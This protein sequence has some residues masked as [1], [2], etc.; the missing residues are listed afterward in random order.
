MHLSIQDTGIGI[1]DDE[2]DKVF[3]AFE[4]TKGQSTA[5]Y[6]GTGLGLAITKNLIT[7][8]NGDINVTGVMGE[9]SS[10]NLVLREI[11]IASITDIENMSENNIDINS[12]EFERASILIIDDIETNRKLVIAYLAPFNF[13]L[14]EGCNGQDLLDLA[15]EHKPDLILT[16]MKMPIMDGYEATSILKNESG[17]KD[18]PVV[19]LTAS[20]MTDTEERVKAICDGYL[21]KPVSMNDIFV[22]L[23]KYLKHT[24]IEIEDAEPKQINEILEENEFI[25][26]LDSTKNITDLLDKLHKDYKEQWKELKETL[27]I[28]EIEY[29]AQTIMS[30]AIEHKYLPLKKWGS[31]LS[32]QASMFE[33]DAM[34]LT[35]EKFPEILK[36]IESYIINT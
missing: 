21:R 31:Q 15:R 10:F 26:S 8:M 18:I 17:I 27:T 25:F 30:L 9:G 22:E 2:K 19:A 23:T 7:I 11:P 1:P 32:N 14:I 36:E 13:N 24:K 6:G 3:E 29:F 20:V 5:K 16:D 35:L 34:T 4:Q 12:L 28:D 33:I